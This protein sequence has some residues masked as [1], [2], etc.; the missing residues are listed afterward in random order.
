MRGSVLWL[1]I[2]AAF[3]LIDSI[4]TQKKCVLLNSDKSVRPHKVLVFI[5][6]KYMEMFINF[7]KMYRTACDGN[8]D[9]LEVVCMD[10]L[11]HNHL[12]INGLACSSHSFQ[13]NY[14]VSV[15]KLGVVW[16]RRL[17]IVNDFLAE[18]VDLIL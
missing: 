6:F 12:R 5:D 3:G 2:I 9:A 18:G 16:S 10:N 7:L 14:N 1:L 17:Q 8:I 11:C 13:L 15:E 4:E